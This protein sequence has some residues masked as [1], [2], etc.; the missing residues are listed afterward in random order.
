VK[1][2]RKRSHLTQTVSQL[3]TQ[4]QEAANQTV[5]PLPE[6]VASIKGAMQGGVDPYLLVG[7]L[8]EAIVQT[9]TTTIPPEQRSA[10]DLATLTMLEQRLADPPVLCGGRPGPCHPTPE[11]T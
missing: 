8:L 9:L 2:P 10:T 11:T 5:S 4:A 3:S 6:V 1:R 7:V